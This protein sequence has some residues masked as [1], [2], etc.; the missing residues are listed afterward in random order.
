MQESSARLIPP[1]G[2][3]EEPLR[4]AIENMSMGIAQLT[5][6]GG[7]LMVNERLCEILGYSRQELL[8]VSFNKLFEFPEMYGSA[9]SREKS[10][11]GDILVAASETRVIRK[12]GLPVWLKVVLSVE[13]DE[14]TKQARGLFM[15]AQE[16]TGNKNAE[17]DRQELVRGLLRAQEAERAEIA[18]ELLDDVGQN[19]AILAV[20]LQRAGK[21]VSGEPGKMHTS[22]PELCAKA[23]S[24][25]FRISRISHQLH[26]SKLDHLGLAKA[27]RG[28]CRELSEQQAIPVEC[29]CEGIPREL[30]SAIG[31]C[32]LRVLQEALRNIRKHSHATRAKV[33][34]T[35]TTSELRLAVSDNGVGFDV[36]E[37]RLAYGIGLIS[38]QGRIQLAG[39][40]VVI[41]SKRGGGTRI[42][43]SAPFSGALEG[44]V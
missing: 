21:P 22:I 19:L 38:M 27:V 9:S 8:E 34:L 31:L 42:L 18:R 24:I 25:A 5:A 23:H 39:G 32:F 15:L 12:D 10:L 26:S 13:R 44:S 28:E 11:S 4:A 1:S 41:S 20:Q 14:S 2:K 35:G 43:A 3:R 16:I 36:T 17:Q 7:W 33:E 40:E 30:D 6:E 29:S 37:A